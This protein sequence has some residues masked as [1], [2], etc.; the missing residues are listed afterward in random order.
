MPELTSQQTQQF[1][2]YLHNIYGDHI[3]PQQVTAI[4]NRIIQA[5]EQKTTAGRWNEQDSILIT[6]GDSIKEKE[7]APLESLR[8]FLAMHLKHIVSTVHLLPFFPY[9]SDDGFSVIDYKKIN[10]ELGTWQDIDR[11]GRDFQLMFDL[12]INHISQQSDWFQQ[13]KKNH[14]PGKDFFITVPPDTDLSQVVRPRTSPLLKPVETVKGKKHVWATFSHD[15]VDLN[16]QNPDVLLA[17]LDVLLIYLEKG[18]KI[19]R[20]D[21]IAFLWKE[22]GTSCLHLPETHQVVKFLRQVSEV[23][24]PDAIII[25]ETN[26]PNKENLSYFGQFDEA[27]M[28]YQFSLPPL[29]LYTLYT[30]NSDLLSRWAADLPDLPPDATFFNF[31][32]SHDGI[33]MRPLEGLLPDERRDDL[34]DNLKANGARVSYKTNPDGS[35]SPYEVNITYFDATRTTEHS[36]EE[37]HF[38]R[39]IASQTLP[40]VLKGIPAFYIH[41]LLGTTNDYEGVARTG[42][43]RAINRKKWQANELEALL[44]NNKSTP[45]RVLRKIRKRL[46]IRSKQKAFHPD[47][48]QEVLSLGSAVFAVK[49]THPEQSVLSVSNISHKQL[50]LNVSDKDLLEG[51]GPYV[52]LLTGEVIA[53]LSTLMLAPYETIWITERDQ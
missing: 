52:N 39:F 47:A 18:A 15:Q 9:S 48:R 43:A 31:T 28:V 22:L 2:Q 49:R 7:R 30:G 1:T 21:A 45:A 3:R 10:P 23:V 19:I 36:G 38:H 13:F 42:M 25:T 51:I 50:L 11:I 8:R 32:A 16:F 41:S 5:P 24:R 6:Y 34:I 46:L 53:T 27:H 12:V 20:L 14:A 40:M 4:L 29:L 33:G 44:N 17:M 35:K 37:L 26:V